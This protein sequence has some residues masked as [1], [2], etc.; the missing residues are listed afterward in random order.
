LECEAEPVV[1]A[2]TTNNEAVANFYLDAIVA[3]RDCRS[4]LGAVKRLVTP[5]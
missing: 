2:D 3:G 4:N 5:E 1:P